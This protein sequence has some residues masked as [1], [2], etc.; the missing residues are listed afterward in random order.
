MVIVYSTRGDV[1]YVVVSEI[2]IRWRSRI[3]NGTRYRLGWLSKISLCD[4][5]IWKLYTRALD[6]T[7][8]SFTY[9]TEDVPLRQILGFKEKRRD[10]LLEFRKTILDLQ[11][12]LMSAK[13]N[14]EIQDFLASFTDNMEL[15]VSNLTQLAKDEKLPIVF[16]TLKSAF[17]MS[18]PDVVSLAAG[19]TIN[20][21]VAAV[22]IAG[23]GAVKVS[24]YLVGKAN[25]RRKNLNKDTYSYIYHAQQEGII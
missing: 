19:A 3:S 14:S 18:L 5:T 13:T 17:S 1:I 11:K 7:R 4:F 15:G 6:D 10:E 20:P 16:G 8:F 12:Q 25:E 23:S 22:G 21:T 24:K 2:F 9:A